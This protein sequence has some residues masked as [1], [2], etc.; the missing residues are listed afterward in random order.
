MKEK[1]CFCE[2]L[3]NL[4]V[5]GFFYVKDKASEVI[6]DIEAKGKEHEGSLENIGEEIRE[7]CRKR[8]D[9]FRKLSD[10][11]MENLGIATRKEVDELK[12]KMEEKE[13]EK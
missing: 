6:A 3:V 12:K 10:R 2:K 7:G 9:G 4:G 1:K 8:T 13:G 11:M 5:G